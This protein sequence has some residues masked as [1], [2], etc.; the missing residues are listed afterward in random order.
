MWPGEGLEVFLCLW[1]GLWVGL[2]HLSTGLSVP[3]SHPELHNSAYGA[4][5][6]QEGF[7][8]EP[9]GGRGLLPPRTLCPVLA[10]KGWLGPGVGVRARHVGS[11]KKVKPHIPP[12]N[13]LTQAVM[14]VLMDMSSLSW[15][16]PIGWA[17]KRRRV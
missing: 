8:D 17:W 3:S 15:L 6:G 16:A 10:C 2:A 5:V 9:R 12:Q 1:D 14:L 7:S 11:T 13:P 4:L